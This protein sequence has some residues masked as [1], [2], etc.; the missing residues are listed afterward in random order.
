MNGQIMDPWKRIVLEFL[1][2]LHF[3]IENDLMTMGEIEVLAKAISERMSLLGTTDDF[4]QFYG[5]TRTNVASVINRRMIPKPVRRVYYPFS[6]FCKI[7]P[8]KW[9]ERV[10]IPYKP[11][12]KS[13][14]SSE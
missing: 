4:A 10:N 8:Q 7:V 14:D 5:Q 1:E 3:K 12:M 6:A 13:E 2:F 9:H 11:N